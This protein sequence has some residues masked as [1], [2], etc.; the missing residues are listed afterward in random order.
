[1]KE[2]LG[3]FGPIEEIN[4]LKKENGKSVGCGFV[5]FE[6]VQSAAK[7]IHHANMKPF[8]ERTIVV[9]WA[10]PKNAYKEKANASN[11]EKSEIKE[12]PEDD[13]KVKIEVE[14]EEEADEDEEN[15][16]EEDEDEEDEESDDE[17]SD[18]DDEQED[19]NE[20]DEAVDDDVQEIEYRRKRNS[21]DILEGRT[22]FVKNV[23]FRATQ[24]DFKKCME[25][26]GPVEY[27]C[28]CMDRLTEHSKGT[29][30]VKFRVKFFIC[31]VF[32]LVAH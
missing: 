18:S 9:D 30:F 10:L 8:L 13:V 4:I 22:V 5:Q 28:I 6:K 1:M 17:G 11:P 7:A 12:E 3:K 14:S 32:Y 16:D 20:D 23:P 24:E 25:Q 31:F 2:F 27:A 26:F 15:E 19:E 29:A 21:N